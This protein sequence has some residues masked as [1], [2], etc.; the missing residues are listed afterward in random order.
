MMLGGF[1]KMMEDMQQGIRDYTQ[2]GHCSSCGNCCSNFLP[3]SV[4]E[5]FRIR[6]YVQ[7]KHIKECVN[8]P[9]TA[10]PVLDYTCP[11]RDNVKKICTIYAIRPLICKDWQCDKARKGIQANE[12]FASGDYAVIDMRATFFPDS[13]I[14]KS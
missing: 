4:E 12:K 5:C 13:G 8:R 6:K 11:F 7:K 9:P 1:Q 10:K 3:L 2:D 14:A